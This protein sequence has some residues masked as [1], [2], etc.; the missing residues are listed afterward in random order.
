MKSRNKISGIVAALTLVLFAGLLAFIFVTQATT[1]NAPVT[2][3][4]AVP[5]ANSP[6]EVK[7][8]L[9]NDEGYLIITYTD[10]TKQ[11]AGRVVGQPG[12]D[13]NSLLPSQAQ[14]SLAIIEYCLGGKCDAKDPTLDQVYGAIIQYCDGGVCKGLDAQPVTSEHLFTVVSNYCSDG[15]CRGD[16]GVNG[17]DGKNATLRLWAC[18][19]RTNPITTPPAKT[20]TIRWFSW[21]YDNEPD[22]AFR[23]QH[24]I[25]DDMS[26]A[27][28]VDLT[29]EPI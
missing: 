17:I 8:I 3:S 29:G 10:G 1:N 25:P 14:V 23:D 11:N 19:V 21:K 12:T 18:V 22:T 24:T 15:R 5:T 6:R 2:T 26:C 4:I 20:P 16:A 9:T 27:T 13:G 7:D 28:T